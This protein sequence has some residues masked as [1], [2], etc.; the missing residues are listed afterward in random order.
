MHRFDTCSG[1]REARPSVLA[2]V[3]AVCRVGATVVQG[4]DNY[5]YF[6][7]RPYHSLIVITDY[8]L[9]CLCV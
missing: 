3:R 7:Q 8:N 4:F 2:G 1:G 5:C 9:M 6:S